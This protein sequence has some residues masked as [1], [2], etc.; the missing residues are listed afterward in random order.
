MKK[1]DSLRM[2][3]P[4]GVRQNFKN[5]GYG[6]LPVNLVEISSARF[7]RGVSQLAQENSLVPPMCRRKILPIFEV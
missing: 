3:N 5:A 4:Y 2:G 6:L 7:V 1:I